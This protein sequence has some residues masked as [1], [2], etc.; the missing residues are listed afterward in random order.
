MGNVNLSI[1]QYWLLLLILKTITEL[2]FLFPVAVFFNKKKSLWWFPVAQPFH[3]LYTVIAGWLGK[4]G[5]Y[6]WKERSV[7]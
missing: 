1:I 6:Q 5:S 7:K 3:I 4:F 2:F